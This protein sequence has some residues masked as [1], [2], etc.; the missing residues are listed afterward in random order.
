[1][2]ETQITPEWIDQQLTERFPRLA[3]DLPS[4]TRLT[5]KVQWYA[6]EVGRTPSLE[7]AARWAQSIENE[8]QAKA[9]AEASEQQRKQEQTDA[10][11]NRAIETRNAQRQARIDYLSDSSQQKAVVLRE[12][13]QNAKREEVVPFIPAR[14]YTQ[15]EINAMSADEY[16][17]KM[18]GVESLGLNSYSQAATQELKER[19]HQRIL[20][21]RK[22]DALSAAVRRELRR[23]LSK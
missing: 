2:P 6:R 1:M 23:E 4:L 10:D 7:D 14:D 22:N 19:H 9:D 11:K 12:F 5:E 18:F 16:K 3:Q 8:L 21:S 15:A 20:K 13:A 17:A